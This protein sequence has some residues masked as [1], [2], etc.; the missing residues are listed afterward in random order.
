MGKQLFILCII[1]CCTYHLNSYKV[2][3]NL[4][5][6]SFRNKFKKNPQISQRSSKKISSLIQPN[7]LY[8]LYA[9]IAVSAAL[10]LQLEKKTEIGKR[11]SGPVSAMF[12]AA[13]L[14][15]LQILPS[16]PSIYISSLQSFIVKVATPLLLFSANLPTIYRSSGKLFPAFFVGTIGTVLGSITG[17][18]LFKSGLSI[19]DNTWKVAGAIAAKNIGGGLNFLGV[20]D[21]L[22]LPSSSS[23]ASIG[24]AVDN[25]MGLFY[26]PFMS[27]VAQKKVPKIKQEDDDNSLITGNDNNNNSNSNSINE[28]N[29]TNER[30]D[31][32]LNWMGS[33]AIALVIATCAEQISSV[34]AKWN[35]FTSSSVTTIN[36]FSIPSIV[37]S[38]L[39]T[40]IFATITPQFASRFVRSGELLGQILLY[41]FFGSIGQ[42]AGNFIQQ[43]IQSP[44][45][46]SS[47]FFYDMMLYTIHLFVVFGLGRKILKFT[48]QDLIIASNANIGNAATASTFAMGMGWQS[49][50]IPALLVG[51]MGNMMGTFVGY[52]LSIIILKRLQGL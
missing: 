6:N 49:K 46:F 50:I 29:L 10:G 38:T 5:S 26:F 30:S 32:L 33:I 8:G 52:Y 1:F 34:I 37:W 18:S 2:A 3:G 13:V 40:V 14:T 39:L 41:L 47:L 28:N 31:D 9:G 17:F 24:L 15:N 23:L 51:N 22:K 36:M 4:K 11:L 20:L 25:I 21:A 45:L 42:S 19:D 16:S 44:Q 35:F 12:I 48:Y 43:M 27:F 7:D